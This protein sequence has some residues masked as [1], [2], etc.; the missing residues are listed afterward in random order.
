MTQRG[1]AA[2]KGELGEGEAARVEWSSN[3]TTLYSRSLP[4]LSF[5]QRFAA[6]ILGTLSGFD[7]LRFRGTK[8]L[9][10]NVKGMMAFLWQQQMRLTT[11]TD[12]VEAATDT[13]RQAIVRQVEDLARPLLYL[14]KAHQSK[15]LVAA[16]Q[17]DTKK[18]MQ[19]G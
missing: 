6:H 12:Y 11:F 18:L 1:V 9:L 7:H 16:L 8:W 17:A 5:V 19:A 15:A 3:K 4:R 13:V 14:N 10:A 2:T